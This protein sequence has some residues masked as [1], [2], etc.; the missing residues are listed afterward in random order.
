[1]MSEY[2]EP[3]MF[4]LP[5]PIPGA[6][7]WLRKIDTSLRSPN[8]IEEGLVPTGEDG[9]YL[10]SPRSVVLLVNTPQT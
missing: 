4:A 9:H 6:G 10:V 5:A 3:L 8:D 1:M 2:W 7:P